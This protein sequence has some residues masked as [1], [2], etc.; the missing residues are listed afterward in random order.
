MGTFTVTSVR[1]INVGSV[2]TGKRAVIEATG[3]ASY[4]TGG[5]LIDLSSANAVLVALDSQASFTTVRGIAPIGVSPHGSDIYR[6]AFVPGASGGPALGKLKL[7]DLSA[8]SDAEVASTTDL[9]TTTFVLEVFG[10]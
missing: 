5:S 9:H 7:R 4:D 1:S 3:P 10:T 2:G 6:P 8:G